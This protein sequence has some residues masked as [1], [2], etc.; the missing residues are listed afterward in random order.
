[1][2]M[3]PSQNEFIYLTFD[4]FVSDFRNATKFSGT[5][6]KFGCVMRTALSI[7]WKFAGLLFAYDFVR[8]AQRR[9]RLANCGYLLGQAYGS[10]MQYSD[11]SSVEWARRERPQMLSLDGKPALLFTGRTHTPTRAHPCTYLQASMNCVY[12]VDETCGVLL[13]AGVQPKQGLSYTQV[14]PIM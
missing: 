8:G 3:L 14:Q 7:T 5:E 6:F 10:Q 4:T 1:M 9:M 2:M 12:S 11:G 13:L